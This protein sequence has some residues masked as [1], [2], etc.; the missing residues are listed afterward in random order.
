MATSAE[1]LI[2]SKAELSAFL[3]SIPSSSTL[4]FDFRGYKY[5]EYEKI[6]LI[7]VLVHPQGQIR[8]IDVHTLRKS[9][10]T[11]E[12]RDGKSLRSILGDIGTP[13]IHWDLRTD[14]RALWDLYGV[15]IA[16][17]IDFQLLQ[18][19]MQLHEDDFFAGIKTTNPDLCRDLKQAQ[20]TRIDWFLSVKKGRQL[21]RS[22]RYK[23]RPINEKTVQQCFDFITKLQGVH[24]TLKESISPYWMGR[25]EHE[26]VHRAQQAR[27]P[28]FDPR[29][30]T[31]FFWN[32]E[33]QRYELG[34]THDC[35]D[36]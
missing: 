2:A 22:K 24:D 34:T 23:E 33:E 27:I 35:Y 14:A 36:D 11:T 10:F 29:S 5:D 16:G 19:N 4:F 31:R 25:V 32:P 9:A 21:E 30:P 3:S 13:K 20:K 8:I 1:T 12:S 15:S 28:G 18:G 6:S 17:A 26:S 7:T